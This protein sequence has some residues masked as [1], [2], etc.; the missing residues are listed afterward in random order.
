MFLLSEE[1]HDPLTFPSPESKAKYKQSEVERRD[2]D[3]ADNIVSDRAAKENIA[4]MREKLSSVE[5]SPTEG[6]RLAY[7]GTETTARLPPAQAAQA[8]TRIIRATL[9]HPLKFLHYLPPLRLC[10][11][12]ASL[13]EIKFISIISHS[14]CAV[15]GLVSRLFTS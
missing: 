2:R 13:E 12:H 9:I 15:E 11:T 5:Y 14:S 10:A 6:F 8:L 3:S 4:Q 7:P 1:K